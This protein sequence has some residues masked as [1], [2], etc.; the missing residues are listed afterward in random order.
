MK[1]QNSRLRQDLSSAQK[2]IVDLTAGEQA[3]YP[4]N[5]DSPPHQEPEPTVITKGASTITTLRAEISELEK[6]LKDSLRKGENAERDARALKK[7]NVDAEALDK[8][9]AVERA[10]N[11]ALVSKLQKALKKGQGK[12][13]EAHSGSREVNDMEVGMTGWPGRHDQQTRQHVKVE[14]EDMELEDGE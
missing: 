2:K 8:Q 12:S 7:N 13:E 5:Q 6:Q 10:K 9:L 3:S 14:D 11:R 1:I 4:D